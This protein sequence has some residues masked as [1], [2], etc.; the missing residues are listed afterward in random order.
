MVE[1]QQGRWPVPPGPKS[2]K[3][4]LLEMKAA[5]E[6]ARARGD[7]E[8]AAAERWAFVAHYEDLLAAG[9]AANPPPERPPGQRG[10]VKQSPARNLLERLSL[11]QAEVLAFLHDLTIPFDNHQA[12]Q[13]L[14]MRKVQQKI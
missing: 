13:A 14:R 5:V 6:Q 9:R 2:G 8:L 7:P 4:L 3:G 11:G 12:E 1:R 10:R